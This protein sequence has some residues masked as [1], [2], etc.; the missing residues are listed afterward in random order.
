MNQASVNDALSMIS[1]LRFQ[2]ASQAIN[3]FSFVVRL[4]SGSGLKEWG[5]VESSGL[6]KQK[7]SMFIGS[8]LFLVNWAGAFVVLLVGGIVGRDFRPVFF[9]YSPVGMGSVWAVRVRLWRIA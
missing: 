6:D 8:L 2:L 3:G 9:C 4:G 5:M 1:V 7:R